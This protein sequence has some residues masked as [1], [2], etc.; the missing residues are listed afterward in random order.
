M[1]IN[2]VAHDITGTGHDIKISMTAHKEKL[3]R[4][5]LILKECDNEANAL[6]LIFH[7]R[8]LGKMLSVLVDFVS[9]EMHTSVRAYYRQGHSEWVGHVF[10]R[11][12]VKFVVKR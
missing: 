9:I 12:N 2:S 5:Q 10:V 4:E 11:K 3:V 7:A 1:H 6:T 8:V